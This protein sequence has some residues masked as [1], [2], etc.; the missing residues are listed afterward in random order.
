MV[1]SLTWLNRL[2]KQRVQ[3]RLN[4]DDLTLLLGLG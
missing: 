2:L 3:N 4:I 1:E